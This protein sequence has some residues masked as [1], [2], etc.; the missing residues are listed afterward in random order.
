MDEK[1][2]QRSDFNYTKH[3]RNENDMKTYRMIKIQVFLLLTAAVLFMTQLN[4][5]TLINSEESNQGAGSSS[6]EL[7]GGS[8]VLTNVE[9]KSI[10]TSNITKWSPKGTEA[11]GDCSWK[12]I[13]EIVHTVSSGF[14]W[15]A[16]PQTMQPGS[17]MN[18]EAVY[19]NIDYA[20]TAKINTGIK[21]FIERAGANY[22]IME[23]NGIEVLKLNK[24]NK[25]YSNEVKKGFFYA[26]K[27]LFGSSNECQ[28]VV[29]CYVGKDHYVTSYS[30]TYQQ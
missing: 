25:Q 10:N 18:L 13:L 16:P 5:Q 28:L 24:D 2:T 11:V 27:S 9:S 14:K 3:V 19:T 23:S 12:D 20:T 30:Y 8:W 6:E 22:L 1:K 15:Q 4:A 29:D 7:A 26:P 21:I 17:Y